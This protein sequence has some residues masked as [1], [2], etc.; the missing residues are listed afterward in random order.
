MTIR[1]YDNDS[2]ELFT[3]LYYDL[4]P[5]NNSIGIP[6]AFLNRLAGRHN[7]YV[8]AQVSSGT[9]TVPVRGALFT[10]DAGYLAKREIDLAMDICDIAIRQL[11]A[12]NGPNEIWAVGLDRGVV[13]IR[14][15]KYKED[16]ANVGW[17]AVGSLGKATSAAIEFDGN[18]VL[19]TN[20][21]QYT[22]ETEEVPWYFWINNGILYGHR[23]LPSEID[24][25]II[26]ATNVVGQVKACKGYSSITYPDHDQGLVVTYIKSDGLVYYRTYCRELDTKLWQP[27]RALP[28]P[29]NVYNFVNVHR[30]NDYRLAF[31][32]SGELQNLWLITDR[33][34]VGQSAYPER[35]EN[36]NLWQ[37]TDYLIP[38]HYLYSSDYVFPIVSIANQ[39]YYTYIER[40]INTTTSAVEEQQHYV[41]IIV[42]DKRIIG[43][44]ALFPLQDRL[45]INGFNEALIVN[46][47]TWEINALNTIITVD[48]IDGDT[49][50]KP[51][52]V[53]TFDI[54]NITGKKLLRV[55][56]ENDIPSIWVD[57]IVATFDITNYITAE[58]KDRTSIDLLSATVDYKGRTLLDAEAKEL[59]SIGLNN[60]LHE[61]KSVRYR[62]DKTEDSHDISLTN[63]TCT[64]YKTGDAPV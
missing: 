5:G 3:P 26:L 20:T 44:E 37:N 4:K 8:T 2:E 45:I 46:E 25:A 31:A 34:Y 61:Y 17:T 19:R 16:N 39:S 52:H 30:L 13:Y 60:I 41:Y 33:T 9:F 18:W 51:S 64:Y 59:H 47:V 11:V 55:F 35:Y 7:F 6:H 57:N 29:A 27:E 12:D 48:C 1:F 42:L 40:V 14:Y 50:K 56:D 63:H 21:E 38:F 22:L 49:T 53:I 43:D 28:V 36:M 10:I 15:R 54:N 62:I 32:L 58:V 23:G 24:P